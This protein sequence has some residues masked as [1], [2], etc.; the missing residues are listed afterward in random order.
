VDLDTLL[1]ESDI[2]TLHVPLTPETEHMIGSRE[3]AR[4]KPTAILIN[5][6][7]GKVVDE[8]ALIESS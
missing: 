4:M 5:T 6:A 7:R 3:L 2:F 8:D 1:S